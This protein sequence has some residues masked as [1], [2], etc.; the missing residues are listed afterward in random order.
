MVM[1]I[2]TRVK[3]QDHFIRVAQNGSIGVATNCGWMNEE[4]FVQY[5]EH[6]IRQTRCTV[7]GSQDPSNIG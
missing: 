6:V 3:Y 5:V 7:C 4:L 1:F 2:L